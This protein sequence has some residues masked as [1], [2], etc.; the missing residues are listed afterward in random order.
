M[1][2]GKGEAPVSGSISGAS[3]SLDSGDVHGTGVLEGDAMHGEYRR[4]DGRRGSW[5][6]ARQQPPAS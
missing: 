6:A 5:S 2:A 3:V 1:E 4:D